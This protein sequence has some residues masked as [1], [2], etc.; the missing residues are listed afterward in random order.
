MIR[1]FVIIAPRDSTPAARLP[2]GLA[3]ESEKYTGFN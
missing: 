2:R 3:S 1:P